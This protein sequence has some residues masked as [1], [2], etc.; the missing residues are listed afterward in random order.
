MGVRRPP[1]DF[2]LRAPPSDMRISPKGYPLLLGIALC[3]PLSARTQQTTNVTCSSTGTFTNCTGRTTGAQDNA[4][5]R[6]G[7]ASLQSL[8][9][10][11]AAE[12][13]AATEIAA[14]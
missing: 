13:Q 7:A 12:F 6:L 4:M 1:F 10:R 9:M 3:L 8:A 5:L 2:H 14:H 11:R